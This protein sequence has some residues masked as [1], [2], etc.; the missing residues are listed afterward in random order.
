MADDSDDELAGLQNLEQMSPAELKDLIGE[1]SSDG[2]AGNESPTA[3]SRSKK[4]DQ[5]DGDYSDLD[6]LDLFSSDKLGQTSD[7]DE[8]EMTSESARKK[9]RAE[10]KAK[11]RHNLKR[12]LTLRSSTAEHHD[13]KKA[14]SGQETGEKELVEKPES[15]DGSFKMKSA[16]PKESSAKPQSATPKGKGAMGSASGVTFE[17]IVDKKD[18]SDSA[19]PED[20]KI[21]TDE[22][23]KTDISRR[24]NHNDWEGYFANK[25][26]KELN[27]Q[28]TSDIRTIALDSTSNNMRKKIR[29]RMTA[30]NAQIV[31]VHV[32]SALAA[33][34]SV[35]EPQ[36]ELK[37]ALAQIS[38]LRSSLDEFRKKSSEKE[39]IDKI[40]KATTAKK[41]YA[42]VV[43]HTKS[44]LNPDLSKCKFSDDG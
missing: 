33:K 37:E 18:K 2:E 30:V 22:E 38:E 39:L 16:I 5:N 17:E 36:S 1:D 44:D 9:S 3:D 20:T 7:N 21:L 35:P 41:S 23:I 13:S 6:E 11:T 8:E 15:N 34:A 42:D 14:K 27:D 31:L 29:S 32:A 24:L 28:I 26:A 10:A 40:T 43:K 4:S 19:K 25:T 12:L